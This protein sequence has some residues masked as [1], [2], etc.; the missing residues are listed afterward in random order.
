M[1]SIIGIDLGANL[2]LS[3]LQLV[4]YSRTSLDNRHHLLMRRGQCQRQ[5]GS[6]TE[7]SGRVTAP[8]AHRV[9]TPH[10]A[11]HDALDVLVHD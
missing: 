1:A 8:S 2:L 9:A 4:A 10:T 3:M 7:R 5:S 6:D 11:P